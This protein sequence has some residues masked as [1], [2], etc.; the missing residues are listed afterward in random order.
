MPVFY[1]KEWKSEWNHL[2]LDDSV[3]HP[4]L[5]VLYHPTLDDSKHD[6]K[7]SKK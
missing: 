7:S 1:Y 4:K 5:D 3:S 2:D 6:C